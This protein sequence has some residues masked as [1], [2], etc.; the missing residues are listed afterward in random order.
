MSARWASKRL[1]SAG[2]AGVAAV[3]AVA[4]FAHA[5][6]AP[7]EGSTAP[8]PATPPAHDGS[9]Q[10]AAKAQQPQGAVTPDFGFQKIRVGVQIKDGSWVPPGTDTGGTDVSI[11]ETGPDAATPTNFE[12]TSCTTQPGSEDPGSTETYCFFGE[13]PQSRAAIAKAGIAVPNAPSSNQNYLA[14]PGDTVTFA[15]TTV[16]HGLVIDSVPQ[17]VG[18]CVNTQPVGGSQYPTCPDIENGGFNDVVFNDP[19]LPPTAKNDRATVVSGHT[20]VIN[21]L[22]NDITHG[23][24][25]KIVSTTRAKHGEVLVAVGQAAASQTSSNAKAPGDP[26]YSI[27]YKSRA[28]YVGPDKFRYTMSTPNGRSTA[29]VFI[30]V[31]APPPTAVNDSATTEEG[32][33]VTIDVL[34]NDDA[35]GGGALSVKSVGSPSNGTATI[36]NGEIVY[37]PDQGFSGK[38]T[39]RYT[40][41]TKFGTDTA[42]VTVTVPA[43]LAA[44]GSSSHNLADLGLLL[45]ITGGAATVV[46]RR[47]YRAKHVG[48]R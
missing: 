30:T 35:N 44:T 32:T 31:I 39:F 26:T 19:G 36:S 6:P 21:V 45:L 12:G 24:P 46:G 9:G 16:N 15:Q 2:V 34:K 20:V 38:D 27:D 10:S 1:V 4:P 40:N 29:T 42:I 5:D 37:T 28:P 11:D 48:I 25:A 47:R 13:T 3:F 41:A 23:A 22:N 18:P 14:F 8:I 7:D 17:T 43:A 33:A